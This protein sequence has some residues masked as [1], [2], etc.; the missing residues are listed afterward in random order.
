[1]TLPSQYMI[2]YFLLLLTTVAHSMEHKIVVGDGVFKPAN[3]TAMTG[4]KITFELFVLLY[5]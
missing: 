1:M 2:L 4:D 5:I 3:I